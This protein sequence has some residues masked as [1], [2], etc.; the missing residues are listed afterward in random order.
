MGS[1]GSRLF[2]TDGVRGEANSRLTPDLALALGRA[3]GE[4]MN[5]GPVLVGRDTR[6]S[7]EMLSLA[8][9][10]GL[11]SVGIDTLDVGVLPAG[12]I[13]WSTEQTGATMGA[14]ISASHNP[15]PDNGIKLL[16]RRGQKLS[17]LAEGAIERRLGEGP[18]WRTPIGP[19][20]GTRMPHDT[21]AEGYVEFLRQQSTYSLRGVEVALD[22][23]N[24]AAFAVAP[25]LFERLKA[26]ARVFGATPDGTNIN[27]GVGATNPEYLARHAKGRIGLCFDGDADRLIAVDED[28]R[29]AN[30]DVIMAIIARHLKTQDKLRQNIIVG[31]V[32]ANLGFRKAMEELDIEFVATQVGDRYVLETMKEIGAG[33][34]GEQSGH[35]IFLDSAPGGDGLLTAVKLMDVVASSGKQLRQLRQEVITEYPQVLKNVRVGDTSGLD[36]ARALWEAVAEAERSMDG[37]GRVLVRASGTEPLIRVMVEAATVDTANSIADQLVAVTERTFR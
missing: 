30:G 27:E 4:G 7:G 20:V 13:A 31:T 32:M 37:D 14:V 34:G 16:D 6:R 12:G 21:A 23:A 8:F 17:D 19:L 11:H 24:G 25:V 3:T 18:P 2:G 26:D 35:V 10:A 33:L 28:G 15:A 5:Q 22:C 36:D 29:V 9:Q 1:F